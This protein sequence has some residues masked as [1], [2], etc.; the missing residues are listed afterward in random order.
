MFL[1]VCKQTFHI[2]FV[3]ISR[4]LKGAFNV[5]F[6]TYYFHVKTKML[7][8][9]QICI[10]VPLTTE[11]LNRKIYE[12]DFRVSDQLVTRCHLRIWNYFLV[13]YLFC[14]YF[15]HLKRREINYKIWERWNIFLIYYNWQR[16]IAGTLWLRSLLKIMKVNI[17]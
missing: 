9:F 6:S 1:N 4:K 16:V 12:I 7:A 8:D 14:G 13:T 15:I 2:S 10:S 17:T 5:K 3:H 11:V